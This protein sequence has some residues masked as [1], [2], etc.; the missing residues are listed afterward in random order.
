LLAGLDRVD[1]L[2]TEFVAALE[3]LIRHGTR[4]VVSTYL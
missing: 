4:G 1:A 2:F 3:G